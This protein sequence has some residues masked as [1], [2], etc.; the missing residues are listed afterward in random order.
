VDDV[1]HRRKLVVVGEAQLGLP[2]AQR[3]EPD[4]EMRSERGVLEPAANER[5][6]VR[7]C[8]VLAHVT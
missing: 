5:D 2:L 3:L 4:A 1:S 7:S 8:A 6:R